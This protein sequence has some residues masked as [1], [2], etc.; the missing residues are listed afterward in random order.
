[1]FR[2]FRGGRSDAGICQSIG[3][4]EATFVRLAAAVDSH[5]SEDGIKARGKRLLDP[6]SPGIYR[7][8]SE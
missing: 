3:R 2:T 7:D 1:M 4:S 6:S 5:V 8:M